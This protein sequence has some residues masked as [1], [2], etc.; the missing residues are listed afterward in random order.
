MRYDLPPLLGDRL[1]LQ[2]VLINLI[3]NA[4]DAMES[5]PS[6]KRIIE[7]EGRP[8]EADERVQLVIRDHGPGVPDLGSQR[9]FEPFHSTKEGALGMGLAVCHTIIEAH[10]GRI[11]AQNEDGLAVYLTLPIAR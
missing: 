5:L 7:I 8:M 1:Q 11:E 3:I 6:E 4:I 9:I 2:Q 10:H